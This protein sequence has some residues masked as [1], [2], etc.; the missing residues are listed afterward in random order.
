MSRVTELAAREAGKSHNEKNGDMRDIC[1]VCKYAPDCIYPRAPERPVLQC[2][3][4][5]FD[6]LTTLRKSWNNSLDS[7][8]VVRFSPARLRK[9]HRVT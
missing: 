7:D 8:P 3:E 5:A 6:A 1:A 4:F 9:M 2:E